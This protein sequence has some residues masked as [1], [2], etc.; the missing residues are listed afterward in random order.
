MMICMCR[1]PLK[2]PIQA[3]ER[4]ELKSL[5]FI[6]VTQRSPWGQFFPPGVQ[7]RF[8]KGVHRAMPALLYQ[9]RRHMSLCL[10]KEAITLSFLKV[11]S[12]WLLLGWHHG[13]SIQ[14]R[15]QAAST[16]LLQLPESPAKPSLPSADDPGNIRVQAKIL[17]H[18]SEHPLKVWVNWYV[19]DIRQLLERALKLITFS[20]PTTI[21]II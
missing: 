12:D 16:E 4:T 3:S 21:T 20:T 15:A 14:R 11:S 10:S 13:R 19:I 17:M 7:K 2:H 5:I 9:A 6:S 8:L 1:W 18:T